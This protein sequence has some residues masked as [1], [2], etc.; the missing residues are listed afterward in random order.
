MD[1]VFLRCG[2]D[3][4]IRGK[5]VV[6]LQ[7]FNLPTQDDRDLVLRKVSRMMQRLLAEEETVAQEKVK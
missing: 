6:T 4:D 7:V 1:N 3:Q 5:F 2:W